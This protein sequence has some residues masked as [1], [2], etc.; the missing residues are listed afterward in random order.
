MKAIPVTVAV[1]LLVAAFWLG[2]VRPPEH[3]G[4]ALL[5]CLG[6]AMLFVEC[7]PG[8]DGHA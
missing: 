3:T 4:I 6:A 2:L 1:L 5:C 7:F 8:K